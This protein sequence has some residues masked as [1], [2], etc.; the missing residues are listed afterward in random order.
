MQSYL[1]TLQLTLRFRFCDVKAEKKKKFLA[2]QLP[3]FLQNLEKLLLENK[4]GD[5]YFVG[6]SVSIW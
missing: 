3:K 2:E 6:D 4:G 5:G 1:H